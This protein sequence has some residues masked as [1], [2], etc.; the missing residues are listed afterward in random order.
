MS[1]F[2]FPVK[3]EPRQKTQTFYGLKEGQSNEIMIKFE[4][5]PRPSTGQ[6]TLHTLSSP[7][8]IGAVSIDQQFEAGMIEDGVSLLCSR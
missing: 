6:W 7:L 3:P 4:A 2:A 1:V 5:N 8:A